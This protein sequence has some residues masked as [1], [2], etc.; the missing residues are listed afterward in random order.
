MSKNPV[1]LA[2]V[3]LAVL[4]GCKS[5]VMDD[6]KYAP[7][8]DDE[9]VAAARGMGG[10]QQQ[11]DDRGTVPQPAQE[12]VSGTPAAAQSAPQPAAQPAAPAP[13]PARPAF[14]PMEKKDYP[15]GLTSAGRGKAAAGAAA[16]QGTYVVKPGDNPGKIARRFNVSVQALLDANNM[17]A[18]DAKKLYV[19]RKLVIPAGAKASPQAK[20]GKAASKKSKGGAEKGKTAAKDAPAAGGVYVVKPGDFPERIAKRN[21]V[22]LAD[23]L[24]ANNLT[25]ESSRRLKVGQK[26]VIPGAGAAPAA[27]RTKAKKSAE[28]APAAAPA[29]E[30][31]PA[32][33]AAPADSGVK[34]A[35]KLAS[36]LEKNVPAAGST[37]D[38]QS[39]TSTELVEIP[40]DTT[41]KALAAKYNTTES[42]LRSL[43]TENITGD[44]VAKGTFF[45]VPAQPKK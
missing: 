16:E 8:K 17:T 14:A 34:E 9:T 37:A 13:A 10:E 42:K 35:D 32:A 7:L 23:L 6:R 25:I 43:N 5:E 1:L 40:E 3:G 21:N 15:V 39:E 24:S 38:A 4:A 36:D 12:P 26:L 45:F 44:T 11:F 22:K 33:A 31:A 27:A 29:A 41:L 30:T 19:G 2:V 20:K 18:K 28:K